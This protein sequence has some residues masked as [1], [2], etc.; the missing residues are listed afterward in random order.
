VTRQRDA[1][2]AN[3]WQSL[4]SPKKAYTFFYKS[5]ATDPGTVATD[6]R[7][8]RVQ[9]VGTFPG[10]VELEPAQIQIPRL[11]Y[12][13]YDEKLEFHLDQWQHFFLERLQMNPTK[14]TQI[15]SQWHHLSGR[16]MVYWR[17]CMPIRGYF[18]TGEISIFGNPTFET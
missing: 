5:V 9:S 1:K 16:D 6:W 14:F 3:T 15:Q 10:T 2:M 4:D 17:G 18:P 12:E 8:F 11:P 13:P 7:H